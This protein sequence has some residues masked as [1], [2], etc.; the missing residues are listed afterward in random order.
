MTHRILSTVFAAAILSG[1]AGCAAESAVAPALVGPQYAATADDPATIDALVAER[2]A[3]TVLVEGPADLEGPEAVAA[4]QAEVLATIDPDKVQRTY[5]HLPAVAVTAD[6]A[7]LDAL[8]ASD[9]VQRTA[10]S[11]A[12][13]ASAVPTPTKGPAR[14]DFD[15]W[16]VKTVGADLTRKADLRGQ[17][18]VIA[19]IDT[20]V[21][22]D[23]PLLKD[24]VTDG[25]C[26]STEADDS[27]SVCPGGVATAYGLDAGTLCDEHGDCIHGTHVA[28]IAGGTIARGADIV[29]IQ[30]FT[31]MPDCSA[32]GGPATPCLT[33]TEDDLLAALDHV[34][35][36]AETQPVAAANM[37]LGGG[38]YAEACPENIHATAI[39]MLR[40]AGVAPVIASGNNGWSEQVTA[41]ACIEEAITVGATTDADKVWLWSNDRPQVDIL[42]PGHDIESALPDRSMGALSGTSMATPH[43]AGAVAVLKS[44]DPDLSVDEIEAVLQETGTDVTNFR[45]GRTTPRL[46]L[47]AAAEALAE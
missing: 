2:G 20:G 43:V 16:H 24:R 9:R 12:R 25:A 21:D 26:F 33:Y 18:Q 41:P 22:L 38:I 5:R 42:A 47:D 34:L 3:V 6:R 30:M 37:S 14:R 19:V 29:S 44:I 31:Y 46:Q 36:L 32:L 17:G 45:N 13:P 40:D 27:T 15:S 23:H 11:I 8:N 10:L 39:A 28:G 4:W 7:T 35:T 1:V